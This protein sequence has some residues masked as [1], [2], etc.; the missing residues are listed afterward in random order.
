MNHKLADDF[1]SSLPFRTFQESE[2]SNLEAK[3]EVALRTAGL[4]ESGQTVGAGS[5]STSFLVF[6]EVARRI[7]SGE[8]S[9]VTMIP[10]SLE[11][12]WMLNGYGIP[13]ASLAACQPDWIFDGAD[14]V[15][16]NGNLIKGRGG[17]L[18]REKLL[19]QST[20]LRRVLVD[21]SKLVKQLGSSVAVPVEVIPSAIEVVVPRIAQLGAN[22]LK[23]RVGGGKDGPVIT[24]HGNVLLD[25]KFDS[26]LDQLESQLSSIPGVVE[27]GLFIGYDPEI[28]Q[29]G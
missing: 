19:F 25:C 18:L 23:I 24:E 17:A 5:G 6:K 12:E 14:E 15:D 16:P 11:V 10:T 27:S 1:Y 8:L 22:E 20:P 26:I 21:E 7:S 28:I 2:I 4:V 29:A 3:R 9:G 13:V